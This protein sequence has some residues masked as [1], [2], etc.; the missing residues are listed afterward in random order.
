[1]IK[2]LVDRQTFVYKLANFEPPKTGL[3]LV[4]F[5]YYWKKCTNNQCEIF[6]LVDFKN[7][8]NIIGA[9]N[10]FLVYSHS[11]R[12]PIYGEDIKL[13]ASIIYDERQ[14]PQFYVAQNHMFCE[15]SICLSVVFLFCTTT[16]TWWYKLYV[17][18][19][20]M[21]VVFWYNIYVKN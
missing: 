3:R 2:K 11:Q 10:T 13:L 14:V 1:M 7:L 8:L 18:E 19:E 21:C 20:N 16:R 17:T 4:L 5:Y 15:T 6:I 9:R 12:M